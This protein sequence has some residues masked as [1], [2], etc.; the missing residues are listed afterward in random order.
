MTPTGIELER[1][2]Y[3]SFLSSSMPTWY[4]IQRLSEG[5]FPKIIVI[6]YTMTITDTFY[7]Y[8]YIF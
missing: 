7:I 2:L 4:N 3:A 5:L 8:I 6:Y 1:K